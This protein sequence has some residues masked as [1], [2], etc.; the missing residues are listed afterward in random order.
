[1]ARVYQA[2][3]SY[4]EAETL[5]NQALVSLEKAFAPE[6]RRIVDVLDAKMQLY[7][8]IGNLTKAAQIRKRADQIRATTQTKP[9]L[10]AK[11]S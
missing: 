5:Y 8:K 4:T 3:G 10:L 9:A 6:H 2:K 1:M 11:A 7:E